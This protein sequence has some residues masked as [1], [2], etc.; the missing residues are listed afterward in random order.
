[1]SLDRY[2]RPRL[3][4]LPPHATAYAAARAMSEH[5]LSTIL[6]GESSSVIGLVTA[7]DLAIEALA[8][9]LDPLVTPLADVMSEP[10]ATL[11]VGASPEEAAQLMRRRVCRR[12][13]VTEDGIP[14]GVVTLDDLIQEGDID[15]GLARSVVMAQLD[16][17]FP[18][19]EP[20]HP[21]EARA[22][23]RQRHRARAETSLHRL[24][25]AVERASG[26]PLHDRAERA[27]G[28]VLGAICRRLTPDEA[29]HFVAQLPSKLHAD[30]LE[31]FDGPDKRITAQS[32]THELR[33]EL[34]LDEGAAG[35]LLEAVCAAVA[36]SI[37]AGG[38]EAVR[39]QLP[40]EM[41][42]LFPA[43]R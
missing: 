43:S 29:R 28:I 23:A 10:V 22:R 12:I 17:A 4:I 7:R 3:I 32:I 27:L 34:D 14:V 20:A 36:D 38:I 13:P 8:A 5:R 31:T 6:V 19:R 18:D 42:T 9:E 30:L 21:E 39:A 40:A 1:M 15:L 33:R 37:S 2:R 26:I 35:D 11:D 16:N 25:R 24:L 41:K